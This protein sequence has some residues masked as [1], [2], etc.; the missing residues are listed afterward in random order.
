MFL[1][2]LNVSWHK[3]FCFSFNAIQ[4]VGD[5]RVARDALIQ[6]TERLRRKC[7]Q[8]KLQVSLGENLTKSS[9]SRRHDVTS[10]GRMEF[11]RLGAHSVGPPALSY[12]SFIPS[13]GNWTGQ[14]GFV[15]CIQHFKQLLCEG[16]SAGTFFSHLIKVMFV[17]V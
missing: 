16:D 6:I 5:I 1:P 13:P 8:K 7:Q 17:R 11:Q 4:I 15:T 3:N 10:P 14:V 12:H 2:I 9:D